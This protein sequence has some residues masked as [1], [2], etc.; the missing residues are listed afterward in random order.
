MSESIIKRINNYIDIYVTSDIKSRGE[1]LFDSG[2][3]RYADINE[4]NGTA[5]FRVQGTELYEVHITGLYDYISSECSCPYDWG[6]VCKHQVAALLHILDKLDKQRP[7]TQPAM[8][9]ELNPGKKNKKKLRLSNAAYRIKNFKQIDRNFLEEHGGNDPL[10]QP[11]YGNFETV[12]FQDNAL[13]LQVPATNMYYQYQQPLVKFWTNKEDLLTLCNC[14]RE[15]V[16]LCPHQLGVLSQMLNSGFPEILNLLFKGEMESY[17]QNLLSLYGLRGE[18]FDDYFELVYHNFNLE[19]VPHKEYRSLLPVSNEVSFKTFL[20][21]ELRKLDRDP[22][23]FDQDKTENKTIKKRFPGFAFRLIRQFESEVNDLLILRPFCG[24]EN[25]AKTKLSTALKDVDLLEPDE[26]LVTN[27]NQKQLIEKIDRFNDRYDEKIDPEEPDLM[28]LNKDMF[29]L[30]TE[31]WPMFQ[32]EK[33]LFI[34]ESSD[35]EFYEDKFNRS[36]LKPVTISLEKPELEVD[37]VEHKKFLQLVPRLYL[38]DKDIALNK[39]YYENSQFLFSNFEDTLYL[40]RSVYQS[41]LIS[42]FADGNPTMVKSEAQHFFRNYIKP[43][44]NHCKVNFKTDAFTVEEAEPESVKKQ[45][46]LSETGDF[47]LFRPVIQYNENI[48]VFPGSESWFLQE[49]DAGVIERFA[50]DL[51]F[52]NELIDF[53]KALHPDFEN[54]D[55]EEDFTIDVDALLED[56][57]FLT[58]FEKIDEAGIE[59]Y[60]AKE[61]KSLKYSPFKAKVNTGIKSGQD[62]FEVEVSI[63]FGDENVDLKSIRKAVLNSQKYIRLSDGSIGIL[64]EEWLKKLEGFFRVGEISKDKL[65]VSKLKF[66]VVDELFDKIDDIEI[67]KEIEA[68]KKKLQN[69][70]NIKNIRKPQDIKASLRNYQKEGLNWLN[71]LHEMTWGGILADDMGLGKTLQ[72]L[73]FIQRIVK[74]DKKTNLVVVPTTLLFNWEVELKKFAPKLTYHV[75][76]GSDRDKEIAYFS[77]YNLILTTYGI[78]T[79]DIQL[80][81][82]FGFNYVILDESQAIKNPLSQRYKAAFLLQAKNRLALTGTPVEN[83][84]VDLYSQ[85]NFVNPGFFG[86][87]NSFREKFTLPIDKDGNEEVLRVLSKMINPFLLRRTK[88]HVAADLPEKTETILYCEMEREQREVYDAFRNKYR[89][90]LMGKI[91]ED[92][93]EKSRIFVLE[94][95]MKLRQVCDSP[96]ILSDEEQYTKRSVKIEELLRHIEEKTSNHKILVFSQFVKMLKL[97]ENKLIK[98]KVDFEYLDGKS[99]RDEREKSVNRFQEDPACRVFLIS[100]KA[101]GVGLNLTAADYVYLID[102]WWNPAVE[103]QAIDRTHR[104]GQGKKVFA[105]RMICKDTVEEKILNLQA[106]KRKIASGLISVDESFAKKLTEDDIRELFSA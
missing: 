32:K 23:L 61:L 30:L 74:Q 36:K 51:D 47:V 104:I 97:V 75:F 43:I 53:M 9:I 87:F 45:I 46:Y 76:H 11:Y 101:G 100:L 79:R 99:S 65:Q 98:H 8:K 103:T 85:M 95:L 58:A 96:A 91:R 67:M 59:V 57:W 88:E 55:G 40:H 44:A 27:E 29:S 89:D 54:A 28:G 31:L 2:S 105:Y 35:S 94:G 83:S 49:N 37:V 73:A 68:K 42:R 15:V 13:H 80:L 1:D 38:V 62:W 18:S 63:A 56:Y 14:S 12:L 102:P 16:K 81:R 77:E 24:K 48:R 60:G 4:T 17:K 84:T 7:K 86:S 10:I 52:E 66:S 70:G 93:L 72:V 41:L 19:L 71:M 106:K 82:D 50:R 21:T 90:K 92:G 39:A 3:I 6:P 33:Y 78:M 20:S 69:I 5:F 64:P 25:K 26:K 22:T 34:D